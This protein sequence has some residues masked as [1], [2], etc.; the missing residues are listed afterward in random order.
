MLRF[1]MPPSVHLATGTRLQH[2]LCS[3]KT[4][5][6]MFSPC[7]ISIRVLFLLRELGPVTISRYRLIGAGIPMLKK[8]RSHDHLTFN[9]EI[10]SLYWDG[11]LVS[12]SV[13][14]I[15]FKYH[16]SHDIEEKHTSNLASLWLISCKQEQLWDVSKHRLS[17]IANKPR[18]FLYIKLTI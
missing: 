4:N 3:C 9:V 14:T 15:T 7:Y 18:S 5:S 10:R 17:S 16:A 11:A 6:C 12:D 13:R 8:G 1:N 2:F